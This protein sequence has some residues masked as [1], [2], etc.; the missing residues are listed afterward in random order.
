[1]RRKKISGLKMGQWR[2]LFEEWLTQ[3]VHTKSSPLPSFD[4]PIGSEPPLSQSLSNVPMKPVSETADDASLAVEPLASIF[5]NPSP[6]KLEEPDTEKENPSCVPTKENPEE[7]LIKGILKS[8]LMLEEGTISIQ[9]SVQDLKTENDELASKLAK[10][11][12]NVEKCRDEIMRLRNEAKDFRVDLQTVSL[13][14]AQLKTSTN[15]AAGI[16]LNTMRSD[17][18]EFTQQV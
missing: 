15:V 1:V 8:I 18:H 3:N 7:I 2:F 13:E 16:E 17:V 14:T 5:N 6:L 10:A 4:N 9:D 12:R 11:E